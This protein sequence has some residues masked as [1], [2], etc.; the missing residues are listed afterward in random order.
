MYFEAAKPVWGKKLQREKNITCG[1]YATANKPNEKAVLRIATAGFYRVFVN[2]IFVYYGPVRTAKGFFRVDEIPLESYLTGKINHIAIE[3]INHYINSYG[4]LKQEGFIQAELLLDGEVV[5]ATSEKPIGFKVFRLTERIR[6]MLRYSF[7]RPFAESY[8]LTSDVHNWRIGEQSVSA[9]P[10]LLEETEEKN[11]L[12]RELPLHTFPAEVPER[13][14]SRGNVRIV[15]LDTPPIRERW[16]TDISDKLGG[17]TVDEL[18]YCLSDELQTF[19]YTKTENINKAYKGATHLKAGEYEIIKMPWELSGFPVMNINALEDSRFYFMIAEI[20]DDNG[21]VNPL[22]A[23]CLDAIR[24]DL[25]KGQYNFQAMEPLGYMYVKLVCLDGEVEINNLKILQ[26]RYPIALREAPKFKTTQENSIY[27]AAVENFCQNAADHFTDCPTRERAG[28]LADSFFIGRMEN[29]F[30]GANL[31]EKQFLENFLLPKEFEYLPKGM[32]PMCYPADHFDG[33]F[34]PNWAMW[35]A[36]ELA[37]YYARTGDSNL[38]DRAKI[39]ME[40]LVGY[41]EKFENDDGLLE[42]L[43]GWVFVEWSKSND[44]V[45]DVSFPSNMEYSAMLKKLGQLYNRSEWVEKGE[46]IAKT[47]RKLSFDGEF[48][49]DNQIYKDGIR[50]LSGERTEACQYFAFF[51][52]IATPETYPK[53]WKTLITDFGPNRIMLG[54]YPEIYPANAF[55]GNY[56][57]LDI[58]LKYGL[59]EQCHKEV[60]GYFAE[61]ANMT[62]TLWEHM[63]SGASCNHGFASYAAYILYCSENRIKPKFNVE[64]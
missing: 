48:F 15:Q 45:Q 24:F 56:L 3:A 14:V 59:Y 9:I 17:Y 42:H 61:M 35:Y 62:G 51:C 11:L 36:L 22:R 41:F 44:F 27:K 33:V 50:V 43:E 10:M 64:F 18:E 7:Q 31:M 13:V 37:D 40:E 60:V 29:F 32:L 39:R 25:K 26:H 47:V 57:R 49:V 8:R 1:F 12:S 23:E 5:A 6:K 30:T 54:L 46:K 21:D 20:L 4:A 19:C 38:V 28:W 55:F 52:G 2:G 53:L 34:I 63:H 16:V 58:L